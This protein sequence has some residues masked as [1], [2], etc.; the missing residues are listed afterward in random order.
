MSLS[1]T[2]ICRRDYIV[3][4]KRQGW[5]RAGRLHVTSHTLYSLDPSHAQSTATHA[6]PRRSTRRPLH[7]ESRMRTRP[8]SLPHQIGAMQTPNL[9]ARTKNHTCAKPTDG[10]RLRRRALDA[11]PPLAHGLSVPLHLAR[12]LISS[13]HSRACSA[14]ALRIA[15]P[16]HADV[17]PCALRVCV[18]M[19]LRRT[20]DT[21]RRLCPLPSARSRRHHSAPPLSSS[22]CRLPRPRSPP[23]RALS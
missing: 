12:L 13:L 3:I 14:P 7:D 8:S 10:G 16:P 5:W 22:T 9:Q 1:A 4:L 11:H 21:A 19:A 17:S 6:H 15:C 18:E 20:L 2:D 23:V